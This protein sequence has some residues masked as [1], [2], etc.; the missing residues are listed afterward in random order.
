MPTILNSAL[1]IA[2]FASLVSAADNTKQIEAVTRNF[3]DAVARADDVR[4]KSLDKARNDA[5][6]Q[7]SKLAT[8]A[9]ADKDRVS[10]TRAWK[11]ILTLDRS[12]DKAVQYFKDL[13]ILDKVLAQLPDEP[14]QAPPKLAKIIGRWYVYRD[15]Q[16]RTPFCEYLFQSD[17]NVLVK[18]GDSVPEPWARYVIEG[19]SIVTHGAN[20]GLCRFTVFGDRFLQEQWDDGITTS[21]PNWFYFG[22]RAE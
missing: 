20:S 10:E 18:R 15:N 14:G 16:A 13:G 4:S 2:F 3:S 17:G 12:H 5:I 6:A 22:M 11:A 21:P 8:K 19:D 7:L 9:F 1:I